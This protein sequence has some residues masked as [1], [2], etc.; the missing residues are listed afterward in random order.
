MN[1]ENYE[2]YRAENPYITESKHYL[3]GTAGAILG[4]IV[5]AIPWA[6][7]YYFGWFVAWLGVVIGLAALKG[8]E[9]LGGQAGALK[10]WI[11]GIATVFGVVLGN[12]GYD[13]AE[14]AVLIYRGMFEG[15]TYMDIPYLY[16]EWVMN[17][18]LARGILIDLGLGL[19][20]AFI[21][22]ASVFRKMKDER[23]I[24]PVVQNELVNQAAD[25]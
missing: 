13:I 16:M 11:I 21:G 12:I 6:V 10:K 1:K 19:V 20:F 3:R 15:A 18:D 23:S 24:A 17:Y 4:A 22:L 8:Y 7:A 2:F 25:E 5:G 9:I 14:F